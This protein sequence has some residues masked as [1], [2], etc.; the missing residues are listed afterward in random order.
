VTVDA[1]LTD[2]GALTAS[3][4]LVLHGQAA[5]EARARKFYQN[6]ETYRRQVL[7]FF[8]GRA[9]GLMLSK[10]DSNDRF[11]ENEFRLDLAADSPAY[12]Q[13]MQGR[14]LVFNPSV[15]QPGRQILP[16]NERRAEP[17]VL[18][19]EEYRKHIRIKLPAG[20][21]VDELPQAVKEQAEWGE[22]SIHFEQKSGELLMEE[23]LKTQGVTLPAGRYK[24][25][26]RFYDRFDGADQQQ[27]V[28]T[29]N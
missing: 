14:L 13:S 3:C 19:A 8:S 6:P 15:L 11:S 22:F 27:A 2:G 16:A 29:K 10:L 12:G 1:D 18:R 4:A 21:T 17:I 23:N 5:D 28:L 7:G 26:K 24:E 25:I 9:S 20:F